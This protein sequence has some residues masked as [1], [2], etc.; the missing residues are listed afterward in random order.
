[1]TPEDVEIAFQSIAIIHDAGMSIS[2][3]AALT[4]HDIETIVMILDH[5]GY[6]FDRS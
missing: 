5:C 3:I 4:G 2:E 1:M 6:S